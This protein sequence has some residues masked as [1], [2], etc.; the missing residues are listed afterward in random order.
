MV[1]FVVVVILRIFAVV[2]AGL[3]RIKIR[4]RYDYI[5]PTKWERM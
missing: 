3:F 5:N 2:L 4:L 1:V